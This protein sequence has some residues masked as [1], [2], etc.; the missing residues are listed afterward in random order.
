MPTYKWHYLENIGS[1][2]CMN[3][4]MIHFMKYDHYFEELNMNFFSVFIIL[5]VQTKEHFDITYTLIPLSIFFIKM[6]YDIT[7]FGIKKINYLPI[8]K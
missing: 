6:L 3:S 8:K 7:L 1:L 5:L 4:L 2:S